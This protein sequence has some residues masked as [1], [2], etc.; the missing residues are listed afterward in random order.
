MKSRRISPA[1]VTAAQAATALGALLPRAALQPAVTAWADSCPRRTV[2]NVALSAGADSVALLLLLWA[3][4]PEH[5]SRLRALHF[6]HR[7]RGAASRGD[8]QFCR[9]LCRELGI[10]LIVGAWQRARA[11]KVSEAT[12][13]TA[14]MA[15]LHRQGRVLWLGH[16]QDDIAE[17][18]LMR[19][20]R[21]SGLSGLAAPRPLHRLADGR[22]LHLRPLLTLRKG[23]LRAALRR[24]GMPWR[25]DASNAQDQF[26]RNRVR[27]RVVPA[28]VRAAGRDAV[29]GAARTRELLEEDERALE[30]WTDGAG[31]LDRRGVLHRPRLVGLPRAVWRRSLQRWLGQYAAVAVSRQAVEAL[32][33]ALERGD[34]TRHSLGAEYFAC[35]RGGTLRL[36]RTRKDRRK[37]RRRV[38]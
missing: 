4:W 37:F 35:L 7:L 31:A 20:A 36:E 34:D 12:A 30:A 27:L 29:A 5:R 32:L 38:N 22:H 26:F 2:W 6:N 9:R 11:D 24:V 16:Q 8:E 21:G 25:E 10:P 17:S 13:R 28:W 1:R 23:D 18:L 3:L 19:L 33:L 15:F 14:R